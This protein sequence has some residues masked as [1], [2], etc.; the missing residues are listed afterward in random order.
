M[1]DADVQHHVHLWWGHYLLDQWCQKLECTW[2]P[3][4]HN[5]IVKQLVQLDNELLD[6]HVLQQLLVLCWSCIRAVALSIEAN[7]RRSA[8]SAST[9][10]T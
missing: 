10:L 2:L 7:T 6:G 8:C 3:S 4:L 9:K 5:E 1:Q